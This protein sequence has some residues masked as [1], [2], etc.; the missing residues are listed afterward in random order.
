MAV[1]TENQK[2]MMES[3]TARVSNYGNAQTVVNASFTAYRIV[4]CIV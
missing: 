3:R 2:M 1:M 4:T